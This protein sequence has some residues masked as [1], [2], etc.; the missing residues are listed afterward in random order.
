VIRAR[1]LRSGMRSSAGRSMVAPDSNGSH[2]LCRHVATSSGCTV[3]RRVSPISQAELPVFPHRSVEGPSGFDG[4]T[5]LQRPCARCVMGE[6]ARIRASGFDSVHVHFEL[7]EA[8]RHRPLKHGGTTR[9]ATTAPGLART[10]TSAARPSGSP[11]WPCRAC[12]S[13]RRSRSRTPR[14]PRSRRVRPR[15]QEHG[16]AVDLVALPVIGCAKAP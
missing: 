4:Q 8:S 16:A 2:H 9:I 12:R 1:S 6:R 11:S 5:L 10:R 7:R 14:R 3:T 15:Q 13:P